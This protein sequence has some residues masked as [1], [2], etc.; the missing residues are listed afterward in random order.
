METDN[1]RIMNGENDTAAKRA[2]GLLM[3]VSHEVR[4][5]L[6]A[7]TEL[8]EL[9]LRGSLP[10]STRGQLRR[11]GEATRYIS[12]IM[13]DLLDLSMFETG[14]LALSPKEFQ[15]DPLIRE[16]AD[17]FSVRC[18]AA[19]VSFTC[20]VSPKVREAYVGDAGRI[21]QIVTNL[22]GSAL[23]HTSRGGEIILDV[24][25]TREGHHSA[26]LTFAVI[27]N[28]EGYEPEALQHLTDVYQTDENAD[29]EHTLGLT[30][31]SDLVQ[32]MGGTMTV[33]SKV[34]VGTRI[35][36]EISLALPD[37]QTGGPKENEEPSAID[38]DFQGRRIL[39]VE[40][41]IV[42]A[43][44]A[45]VILEQFGVKVDVAENGKIGYETVRDAGPGTYDAVLM[46]IQMPVMNGYEST[47][48]IRTLE[49]DYFAA[50]PVI[51]MSAN[52]YDEDVKD[53]LAAGM[54]AHIAKPF[55]PDALV[56]LLC[57]YI[58]SGK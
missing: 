19:G 12:D 16:T 10:A 15:L 28:G 1:T 53:C 57:S 33:D 29:V 52:A 39:L 49:G 56:K 45:S 14:R 27:D 20:R 18:K 3:T 22:L 41:N 31:T 36:V 32:L 2:M 35:T 4:E 55:Q 6:N 17:L 37:G 7:I 58:H 54:N 44:I 21:R 40:D 48:A 5:P 46:D 9:A 38:I 26:D 30:I 8:T 34:H 11:I 13:S 23:S 47:R 42:N 24:R 50:L 51:A 25:Q 43:E